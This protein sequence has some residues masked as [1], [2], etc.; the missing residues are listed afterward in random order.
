MGKPT[1]I[2]L[3]YELLLDLCARHNPARYDQQLAAV[4]FCARELLRAGETIDT[5][6]MTIQT[7]SGRVLQLGP[8]RRD[9]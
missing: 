2:E 9:P 3:T 4:L 5:M 8:I 7:T 6:S 1:A